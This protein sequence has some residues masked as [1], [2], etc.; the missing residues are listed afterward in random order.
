MQV[1]TDAGIYTPARI[2]AMSPEDITALGAQVRDIIDSVL[3]PES[4]AP[5]LRQTARATARGYAVA[6]YEAFDA[7]K[8]A[9]ND[10]PAPTLTGEDLAR[11]DVASRIRAVASANALNARRRDAIDAANTSILQPFG[12]Y[13]GVFNCRYD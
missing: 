9:I 1:V 11:G 2:A 8:R 13:C 7:A 5:I 12:G 3:L 4:D 6:S 10:Q